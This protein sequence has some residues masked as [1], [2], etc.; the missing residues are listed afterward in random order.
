MIKHHRYSEN[1]DPLNV[2]IKHRVCTVL[3]HASSLQAKACKLLCEKQVN[4]LWP[5]TSDL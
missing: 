5:N 3:F 2:T 1:L 4:I